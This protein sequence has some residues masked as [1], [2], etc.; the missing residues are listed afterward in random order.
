MLTN[1]TDWRQPK[2]GFARPAEDEIGGLTDSASRHATVPLCGDSARQ[3]RA[4]ERLQRRPQFRIVDCRD[5][6][7]QIAFLGCGERRFLGRFGLP[8][9]GYRALYELKAFNGIAPQVRVDP[10]NELALQMLELQSKAA[11]AHTQAQCPAVATPGREAQ[12][13][14]YALRREAASD[15]RTPFANDPPVGE[16]ALLRQRRRRATDSLGE[17]L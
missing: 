5:E 7:A 8:F 16:T 14:R 17:G 3:Y 6:T 11:V 10:L 9:L 13:F 15:D 2:Q 4:P 12:L 1:Y